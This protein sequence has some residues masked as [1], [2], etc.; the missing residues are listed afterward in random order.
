V[1]TI[2]PLAHTTFTCAHDSYL[3]TQPP[4][5]DTTI[6]RGQKCTKVLHA[7]CRTLSTY[8]LL[9]P[10]TTRHNGRWKMSS[11]W[12]LA[13]KRTSSCTGNAMTYKGHIVTTYQ[14]QVAVGPE[15]HRQLHRKRHGLKE[16]SSKQ[17]NV[18][19]VA[20]GSWSRSAPADEQETP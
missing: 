3:S 19:S 4:L 13:Q 14:Q 5:V 18:A 20:G 6:P 12:W 7:P 16:V 8:D 1:H 15:V 10:L 9:R 11:R 17:N 2:K